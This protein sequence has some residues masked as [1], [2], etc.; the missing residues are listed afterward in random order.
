MLK[1]GSVSR[2]IQVMEKSS[3]M[4]VTMAAARPSRRADPCWASGSLPARIE[5]KTMLSMPRTIS[6]AMRVANAIQV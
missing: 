4:R 6:S 1:S 5:M 2:V 3:R